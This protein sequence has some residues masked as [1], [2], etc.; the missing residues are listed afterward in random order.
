MS[1]LP[2]LFRRDDADDCR[3]LGPALK[4]PE[5]TRKAPDPFAEFETYD[6]DLVPDGCLPRPPLGQR[7]AW[8]GVDLGALADMIRDAEDALL[9]QCGVVD[10]DRAGPSRVMVNPAMLSFEDI[11]MHPG[12]IWALKPVP[13]LEDIRD[14][15]KTAI[16][17]SG[18]PAAEKLFYEYGA[19]NVNGV[20]PEHR[21]E[22]IKELNAL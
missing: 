5:P 1:L 12:K 4:K 2:A 3:P 21:A 7:P 8:F 22:F 19:R 15:T 17:R 9:Q 16:M 20:A 14:A 13:T 11:D 10:L 18:R 6:H